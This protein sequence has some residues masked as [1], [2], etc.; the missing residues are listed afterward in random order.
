MWLRRQR[1]GYSIS[2]STIAMPRA[3]GHEQKET[4]WRSRRDRFLPGDQDRRWLPTFADARHAE[5]EQSVRV[6]RQQTQERNGRDRF[7]LGNP[8]RLSR[9]AAGGNVDR[10]EHLV[11]GSW[12]IAVASYVRTISRERYSLNVPEVASFP[13]SLNWLYC[14]F[15]ALTEF[16]WLGI[17]VRDFRPVRLS[18]IIGTKVRTVA[19]TAAIAFC[20]ST[21]L[22]RFTSWT[23]HHSP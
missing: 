11:H 14:G 7:L 4:R 5:R 17:D 8:G 23:A 13:A 2:S 20:A 1:P 10:A 18:E 22:R 12:Q 21:V 16:V 15:P 19:S 9:S 6:S 3:G